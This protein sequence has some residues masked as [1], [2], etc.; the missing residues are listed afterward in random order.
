MGH[1]KRRG[2][3]KSAPKRLARRP[4]DTPSYHYNSWATKRKKTGATP[5]TEEEKKARAERRLKGD[6]KPGD[7][8]AE[9]AR[10]TQMSRPQLP[11]IIPG[12]RPSLSRVPPGMRFIY[13]SAQVPLENESG[14]GNRIM[15]GL[16]PRE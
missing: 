5:I 10:S 6:T 3:L 13:P 15:G 16:R 8:P 7:L 14:S 4:L 2:G 9:A 12:P 11:P 1:G